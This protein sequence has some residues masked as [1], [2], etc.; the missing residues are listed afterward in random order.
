VVSIVARIKD[1]EKLI[2][3]FINVIRNQKNALENKYK[4]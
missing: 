2:N 4:I 3:V 1:I